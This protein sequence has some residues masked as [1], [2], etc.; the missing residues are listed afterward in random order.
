MYLYILFNQ[1][2][3]KYY[4]GITNNLTRRL[5][6]HYKKGNKG[7]TRKYKN[8][9]K[10]IFY[11]QFNS[12]TEAIKE[13]SRLKKAKNRKYI[14]WYINKYGAASSTGRATPS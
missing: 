8:E 10:P 2:L 11:R 3:D 1:I 14:Q 4:I 6:E 7:F 5:N 13:E 9:W 12:K